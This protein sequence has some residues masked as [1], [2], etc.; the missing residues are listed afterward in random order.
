M[1]IGQRLR[2]IVSGDIAGRMDRV[3]AFNDGR[4]IEKIPRGEDVLYTVEKT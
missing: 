3:V 1:G 2:F 4:V